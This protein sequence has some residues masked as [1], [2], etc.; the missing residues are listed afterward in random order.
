MD[1]ALASLKPPLERD[2]GT[3]IQWLNKI[4][5]SQN[6]VDSIL[7]LPAKTDLCRASRYIAMTKCFFIL[8]YS[9]LTF[10]VVLFSQA[11]VA[12]DTSTAVV[13][14]ACTAKVRCS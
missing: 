12:A 8:A 13:C 2:A 4:R 5:L 14:G 3:M 7:S 1:R 9:K 6:A 11:S 10:L